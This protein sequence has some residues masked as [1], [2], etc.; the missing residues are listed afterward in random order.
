MLMINNEVVAQVLTM[1][2]CIEV[3]E[4]AFAALAERKA[5]LRPRIDT[6]VPCARPDGY[7]RFGTVEGASGGYYAVRLKSDIV[8]F[9]IGADG[10]QSEQKYCVEPG[11]FCGLVFLYSS[12]NGEPLALMN[13]GHLQHVR[14]GAAAGIGTRL[15]ARENAASVGM[16]GSGGMART[17]LEAYAV[18]RKIRK[19]KVFSRNPENRARY[20][21]EMSRLLGIEVIAVDSAREAVRGVDI[22]STCTDSILP[23]VEPEWLEPGM[24][25]V[26]LT[27]HEIS[28]DV[29]ARF[30]V[31]VQQ[32]N[33]ELNLSE[34]DTFS[35][36]LGGGRGV[37]V[38]GTEEQRKVLPRAKKGLRLEEWPVYTDVMTGKAP[39]RTSRE[40]ITHYRTIGNWGVQFSSVGGLVYERAKAAGL[41][42]ELPTEWFLQ[43]IRN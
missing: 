25:V 8:H 18:V 12:Q 36:D 34:S 10:S 28:A 4:A 1:R 35:H 7:Y 40:Q 21:E 43:D 9:P 38:I 31:K 37:F 15:L 39:G 13:D 27:S 33:E 26:S 20:A 30:D 17:F 16:I 41:G 19:V 42:R 5:I 3:Q 23:T 14:V 6:Y 29:A 11:T 24:H 2:E 32:G 22:L